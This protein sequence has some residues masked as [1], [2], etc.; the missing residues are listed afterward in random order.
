MSLS[1]M[2]DWIMERVPKLIGITF[3]LLVLVFIF[4]LTLQLFRIPIVESRGSHTV[5]ITAI[6][7]N[8]ILWQTTKVYVKTDVAQSQEEVYCLDRKEESYQ[9]LR[10]SLE[11]YSRERTK[12]TINFVDYM[13]N[14]IFHCDAATIAIISEVNT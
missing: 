9:V 13:S 8:G 1:D 5:Q 6:E 3:T 10:T 2:V 14:G 11:Q 4:G 12:V 7:D